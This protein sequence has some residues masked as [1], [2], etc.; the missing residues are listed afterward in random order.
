[1]V[2]DMAVMAGCFEFIDLGDNYAVVEYK[3]LGKV[4]K[5]F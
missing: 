3:Q 2:S 4:G 5:D 1:M